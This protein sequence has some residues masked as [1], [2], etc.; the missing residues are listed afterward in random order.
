MSKTKDAKRLWFAGAAYGKRKSYVVAYIG[1]LAALNVAVNAFSIPLGFT[2]LSLTIFSSV[3]T[4]IL[5]GPLYGFTTCFIGDT[6]GYMIANTGANG[7]TPWIGLATAT[8]A[9]I[10]GL[11]FNG[12]AWKGKYGWAVKLCL[13]CFTT[14]LICTVAINTTAM[15]LLW[16]KTTFDSWW[17]FFTMRMLSPVQIFNSLIN[18]GLLFFALP[19]LAKVKPLRIKISEK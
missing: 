2:A 19:A 16:G 8:M 17:L 15:Y 6:L 11:I 18:Y 13:I 14:F 9:L 1:V 10:G 5:I 7:W 4:G 12:V 3:L